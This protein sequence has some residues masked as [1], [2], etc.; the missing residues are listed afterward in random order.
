[1]SE[2]KRI[3][4]ASAS[5]SRREMLQAAGLAFAIEAAQLDER[6]IREA[7]T[8]DN[9][10]IEPIDI[11][12][13]LARAKA[14]DVSH[15]HPDALVIGADQVLAFEG[16]IFEKPANFDKAREM[17]LRLRG[18]VHQ[19]HSVVTLAENGQSGWAWSDTAHLAMRAFSVAFLEDYIVRAGPGILESVG[20]YRLEELGVQLFDR[21]EGDFF[22]I[23]GMPLVPLLGELR[24]RGVLMS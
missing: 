18:N 15:R 12:E 21:I 5:R 13:V 19:L 24:V 2:P 7:L 10:E 1:M 23:L 8:T 14:E 20:A 4:L 6:A 17:L 22:T 9:A 11:A 16:Q 3:I